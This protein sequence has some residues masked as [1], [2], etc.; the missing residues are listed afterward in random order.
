MHHGSKKLENTA[1]KTVSTGATK[2]GLLDL[3]LYSKI[4]GTSEG[5]GIYFYEKNFEMNLTNYRN[6]SVIVFA[7]NS[8]ANSYFF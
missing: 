4:L 8:I 6:C 2:T 3:G 5:Y 7:L 1:I